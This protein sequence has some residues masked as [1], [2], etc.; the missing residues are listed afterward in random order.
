MSAIN[1]NSSSFQKVNTYLN[2]IVQ[3]KDE[4]FFLS[5]LA[6]GAK[7]LCMP[8]TAIID[9]FNGIR[10]ARNDSENKRH[11]IINKC[12]ISPAQHIAYGVSTAAIGVFICDFPRRIVNQ[13]TTKQL[14]N[15]YSH[16][17]FDFAGLMHFFKVT[18]PRAH[19]N[20]AILS[21]VLACVGLILL[22]P[23]IDKVTQSFA[24]LFGGGTYSI[25]EETQAAATEEQPETVDQ[26]L[27]A[28]QTLTENQD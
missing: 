24:K 9:I 26:T 15:E 2:G 11:H 7:L 17:K 4:R 19:K 5:P 27:T 21:G 25:F 18:C 8:V 10:D 22:T 6:I 12:L 1:A 13:I 28:D 20:A 3:N 23:R 16:S 14:F